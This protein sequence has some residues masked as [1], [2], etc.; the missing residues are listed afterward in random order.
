MTDRAV[1]TYARINPVTKG[2]SAIVKKIAE[3]AKA[4]DADPIIFVSLTQDASKNPLDSQSKIRY[5]QAAFKG[6]QVIPMQTPIKALDWLKA[7]GYDNAIMVVG[8][9]RIDAFNRFIPSD[10]MGRVG[11]NHM[12]LVSAGV[13]DPDLEGIEGVS[14]TK[15]RMAA[16]RGDYN[17]FASLVPDTLNDNQTKQMFDQVRT[18]MGIIG[19][20]QEEGLDLSE[21]I[22][23]ILH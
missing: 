20:P 15:A 19:E 16:E 3:L 10:A 22:G 6:I 17:T 7:N 14:A 12:E 8:D 5:I 2:H 1:F 4:E 23:T 18:G 11:M 21:V 13:R 9:D